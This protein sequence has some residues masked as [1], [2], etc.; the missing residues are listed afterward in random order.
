MVAI[1]TQTAIVAVIESTGY[2]L[3]QE[4]KRSRN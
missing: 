2:I 1:V 4:Q 3:G